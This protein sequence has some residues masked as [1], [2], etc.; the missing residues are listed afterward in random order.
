MMKAIVSGVVIYAV[1][2]LV[3]SVLMMSIADPTIF[4]TV[5]LLIAII[6]TIVVTKEYYFKGVKI[7]K[8]L[9]EGL[10]VGIV[11]VL[12]SFLIEIPVMVYGFAAEVGW[13]YFTSWHIALGYLA[14]LV[15]PIFVAYKK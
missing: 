9:E 12:V 8:P 11:Y 13:N 2:F 5:T 4:G 10:G 14:M 6:L 7:K 3:A 15:V 1:I